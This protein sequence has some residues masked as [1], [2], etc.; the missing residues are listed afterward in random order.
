MGEALVRREGI[1]NWEYIQLLRAQHRS[2][3]ADNSYALFSIIMFD[4]W[5][6]KYILGT[7]APL[8]QTG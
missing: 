6:R 5:Y 3:K 7:E 1:L 4:V 8:I 2:G